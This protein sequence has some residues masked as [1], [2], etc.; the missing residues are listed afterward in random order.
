MESRSIPCKNCGSLE[1]YANGRCKPCTA[2]ASA[3]YRAANAEQ[4]KARKLAYCEANREKERLRA[5][6]WAAAN[7]ERKLAT[8]AAYREQHKQEAQA[9]KQIWSAANSKHVVSKVREW[10]KANPGAHD[11]NNWRRR[12]AKTCATPAWADPDAMRAI[13]AEAKRM[14]RD[15]GI[16]MHVDHI[17]PLISKLVCGLHV[18]NNLQILPARENGRKSNRHWPDMPE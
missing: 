6:A 17:V 9:Y 4:V 15:T 14:Q 10:R 7:R 5:A 3:R 18:E 1:C 12:A 11:A 2:A 8:G 13:Y 16:K